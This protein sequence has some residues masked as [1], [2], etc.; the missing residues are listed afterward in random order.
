MFI[1]SSAYRSLHM[2]R[3]YS[4]AGPRLLKWV[5]GILFAVVVAAILANS[6]LLLF[7][8]PG[9]VSLGSS[10][11]G[12]GFR[13]F[14]QGAS[15]YPLLQVSNIVICCLGL[16]IVLL[17]RRAVIVSQPR[18]MVSAENAGRVAATAVA[19]LAMEVV[20]SLARFY[21]FDDRL[22]YLKI[23]NYAGIGCIFI[24]A[25]VLFRAAQTRDDDGVTI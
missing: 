4:S 17:L 8:I 18:K 7:T 22:S 16:F 3:Y 5:L 10:V 1:A 20:G 23:V 21:I 11:L 24:L 13:E 9:I 25:Y 2:S 12:D 15:I 19:L 14:A 6:A